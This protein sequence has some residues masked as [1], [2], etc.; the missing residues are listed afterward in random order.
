MT[1]QMKVML[2]VEGAIVLALLF[3]VAALI[4]KVFR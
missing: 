1:D 2:L 3:T 4:E